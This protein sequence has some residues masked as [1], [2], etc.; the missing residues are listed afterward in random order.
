MSLRILLT[1]NR[2]RKPQ[3]KRFMNDLGLPIT[4]Q[5]PAYD[6]FTEFGTCRKPQTAQQSHQGHQG[7]QKT[8]SELNSESFLLSVR[9]ALSRSFP[10]IFVKPSVIVPG[11]LA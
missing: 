7:I 11:K 5:R 3:L 10:Q 9:R 4:V 6:I 2:R 8:G 1:S